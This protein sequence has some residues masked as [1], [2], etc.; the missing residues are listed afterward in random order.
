MLRSFLKGL[1]INIIILGLV[2]LFTDLSSQMVFPLLPLFLTTVL[3]ANAAIVGLVE[4]AAEATASLL[5]VFS[6]YWSDKI[7][8]RKPFVLYG[9]TL[10]AAMKP[11]F[12]FSPLWEMVLGVR[13]IERVGKG[14]RN[15][16]RD[17]LVAES[18]DEGF[19]GKAYGL[20]RTMDGVGSILGAVTAYL[21]LPIHGFR[22]TF[23]ISSI[24]AFIAVIMILFVRERKKLQGTHLDKKLDVNFQSLPLKLKLFLTITMVFTIGNMGYAFLLLRTLNLGF[25]N[26][27]AISLYVLFYIT[28]TLLSTPFG[29]ISDR[30]GRKPVL[31]SGYILFSILCLSLIIVSSLQGLIAIF[32]LYG[33]FFALIDGSQRAFVVDLS[34]EELKGTALG[35]FHTAV[36]LTSLPGGVI[37][38]Y[39]WMQIS[40]TATFIF[41]L[42]TSL[43][44]ATLFSTTYIIK[45]QKM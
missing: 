21:L 16:P 38:G 13:I 7:R 32:I 8:K 36:G 29:V 37:A 5:K 45:R 33:V 12:A 19:R 15:A 44:A 23:L 3:N 31:L 11:L 43:L 39:L 42:T 40:P 24:P 18:C 41:G 28:Y 10:S 17:A 6:G 30:V 14:I 4:G 27:I 2:S 35:T 1:S 20:Q 25:E 22:K 26:N 9:Y 34:P